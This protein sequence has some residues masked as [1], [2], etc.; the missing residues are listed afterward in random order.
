MRKFLLV[1]LCVWV[2]V[3]LANAQTYS[4]VKQHVREYDGV[5]GQVE[6]L[7]PYL[8]TNYV[9]YSYDV[10]AVASNMAAHVASTED[11]HAAAGYLRVESPA[12]QAYI[13]WDGSD[14]VSEYGVRASMLASE[15]VAAHGAGILGTL[16]PG[17]LLTLDIAVDGNRHCYVVTNELDTSAFAPGD[18]TWLPLGAGDVFWKEF[19]RQ[20]PTGLRGITG[21]PGD[22]GL[23][24]VGNI[25]YGAWDH[26]KA[27]LYDTGTP[28]VV[29]YAGRWYDCVAS[30]TNKS[31]AAVGATNYWKISVDKGA[32][33]EVVG[34]TNLIF[35]GNWN[36]GDD[37]TTNDAVWWRG[38]LFA[39]SETNSAPPLG[40]APYAPAPS[41]EGLDTAYWTCLLSRGVQGV[42]GDDGDEINSYTVYTL[43]PGTN[44]LF[45][46]PDAPD[47]SHRLPTWV[48]TSGET[49]RMTW[50]GAVPL[51]TNWLSV[52]NGILYLNGQILVDE[53]AVED[54]IHPRMTAVTNETGAAFI[55]PASS[56]WWRV[57]ATSSIT[58]VVPVVDGVELSAADI[59]LLG[60]E[61]YRD[62]EVDFSWGGGDAALAGVTNEVPS[63]AT[64]LH[65][66]WRA[67]GTTNWAGF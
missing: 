3:T 5:A 47:S 50:S 18:T 58:G 40:T 37:Y 34:W 52:T 20:G 19:V 63:G 41:Y 46:D 51:G 30:S 24:G 31:P 65:M 27:Y 36:S 32:D 16:W 12:E 44:T 13:K 15:A 22:D 28:I 4:R 43:L 55:W 14:W 66:L 33:G 39:V 64:S 45:D 35:R 61:V 26:T 7:L 9:A 25:Q 49:L 48:S 59:L 2:S 53:R 17:Q 1:V 57:Y 60:V 62:S 11:P 10:V 67:S 21:D 8:P 42:K 29:S 56:A 54:G 23:D 38:N 6:K